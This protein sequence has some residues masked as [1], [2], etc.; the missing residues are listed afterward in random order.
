M[1]DSILV[2]GASG[3]VGTHLALR[4]KADGYSVITHSE[5]DG[6]ITRCPL[7]FDGVKHVFHL[8]ARTFVPASWDSPPDFYEVNVLGT[9][10]VAEF[11]RRQDAALTLVSSYVYGRPTSVPVSEAH[12]LSA[13]NPYSHSKILAEQVAR[14]YA[15][16]FGL[17]LNV[18]RPF[19]LYGPGQA[20]AF[21]I[22]SLLRQA[23]ADDCRE[24]AVDDDRP[25]RDYLYIADFVSLLVSLLAHPGV[26]TVNAGS[27]VSTS[28][29]ELVEAINGLLDRPKP[30]VCRQ[31]PRPGEVLDTVADISRARRCLGWSP[32]VTLPEGLRHTMRSLSLSPK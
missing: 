18:V 31:L 19:N 11:C 28:I 13:F 8:A 12:P 5:N 10:R 3:F 16:E 27:G 25:R 26:D 2:T 14:Y 24:I 7:A 22:P 30:L 15:Q 29:R 20:P 32:Q 17:R 9:A 6:D 1:S 21:L 23:L 4:L